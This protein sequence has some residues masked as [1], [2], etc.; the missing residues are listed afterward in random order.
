M[1]ACGGNGDCRGGY[2]C[3]REDSDALKNESGQA[4]AQ[5]VD[6]SEKKRRSGFCMALP[7]SPPDPVDAGIEPDAATND[8]GVDAS[9]DAAMDDGGMDGSLTDASDDA[10]MDD[11]AMD[12]GGAIADPP[13]E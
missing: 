9:D 12:D 5:I 7:P 2:Q 10:A 13:I 1:K 6:F 3:V 8:A 4:I 11:A